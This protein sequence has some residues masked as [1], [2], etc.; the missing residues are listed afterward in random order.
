MKKII[1]KKEHYDALSNITKSADRD[2][3]KALNFRV[4]DPATDGR[5]IVEATDGRRALVITTHDIAF[6]GEVGALAGAYVV[7]SAAKVANVSGPGLVEL[8]CEDAEAEF[9]AIDKVMPKQDT[10]KD[11]VVR[12]CFAKGENKGE[13]K[14]LILT[15]AVL[16]IWDMRGAAVNI[17][18]LDALV[19]LNLTWALSRAPE[20][21]DGK[22]YKHVVRMDA[23]CLNSDSITYVV[24]PFAKEDL[25]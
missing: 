15:R 5:R 16:N 10:L 23:R 14:D 22:S 12:L 13:I 20:S 9:P 1:M 18:Y 6:S 7:K 8:I 2:A 17:S 19:P 4:T 24:L 3:L 21:S 25:K 11:A